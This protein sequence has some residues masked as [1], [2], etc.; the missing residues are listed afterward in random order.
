MSALFPRRWESIQQPYIWIP[1]Y[2][3]MTDPP[4]G[5]MR[6]LKFRDAPLLISH[7]RI[8]GWSVGCVRFIDMTFLFKESPHRQ[9]QLSPVP[10]SLV[11]MPPHR[12]PSQGRRFDQGETGD[13]PLMLVVNPAFKKNH[14]ECPTPPPRAD[15]S[16]N[17][18]VDG[19]S[20][21]HCCPL[22]QP[23]STACDYH[24]VYVAVDFFNFWTIP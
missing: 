18:D 2:T 4:S 21:P 5:T 19:H 14:R 15:E 9:T 6:D 23:S 22:T 10:D 20:E 12:S 7:L 13:H 16:R 17:V 1:V 8:N 3:G 11:K 24:Y